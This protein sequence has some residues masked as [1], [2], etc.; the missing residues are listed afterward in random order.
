MY[1]CRKFRIMKNIYLLLVFSV[2]SLFSFSQEAVNK[3]DSRG[4]KQGKWV[5]RY[6]GGS[7]KY[8]GSFANDKP[9]GE[10]KRFHENGKTKAVMTYRGNSDRAFASLFDEEG[11]LYAKGVFE[12]TLRDS[13]W[14]FYSGEQLVQTET[15]LLGKKEGKSQGFDQHGTVLWEKMWKNDLLEGKSIEYYPTGI[16]RNEISYLGGIKSGPALFYDQNGSKSM[17]GAYKDDLSD[18]E[19]KVFDNN[20]KL[21]YQIHY[22]KG[23]ILNGGAIDSLQLNEFKQYDRA[24][25]KIAEPKLNATGQPDRP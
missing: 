3:T 20:G 1:L 17:E 25:G 6:P 7:L 16:K 13:I 11:R 23:N 15:Y 14:N 12:G 24:R 2:V 18:G 22:D 4:M 9:V 5:G 8:E 19:W 10:W 21:K